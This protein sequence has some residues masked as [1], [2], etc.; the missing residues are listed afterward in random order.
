MSGEREA[1]VW[2]FGGDG[3]WSRATG[4]VAGT[5]AWASGIL[6]AL[7]LVAAVVGLVAGV[8]AGMVGGAHTGGLDW[9]ASTG[10]FGLIMWMV[11]AVVVWAVGLPTGILV[12]RAL[13]RRGVSPA[14]RAGVFAA[15]GG[16]LAF[17]AAVAIGLWTWWPSMVVF[18]MVVGAAAAGGG[19]AAVARRARRVSE[20]RAMLPG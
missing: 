6:L 2:R 20:G 3:P 9:G 17:V 7:V 19:R 16:G 18:L 12:E 8:V 13:D 1:R 4:V 10:L 11:A 5:C 15:L 14:R